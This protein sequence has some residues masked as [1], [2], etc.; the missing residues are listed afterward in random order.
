MPK[1]VYC[2]PS[3]NHPGGVVVAFCD[4]HVRFIN[5]DMAYDVYK[6]LMTPNG[7]DSGDSINRALP[8]AF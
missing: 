7:A 4:G 5:E 1:I 6:Q 8:D 3:S 2:R